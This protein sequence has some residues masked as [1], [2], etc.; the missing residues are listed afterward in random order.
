MWA[1]PDPDH[2]HIPVSPHSS[3]PPTTHSSPGL[4]AFPQSEQECFFRTNFIITSK[5]WSWPEIKVIADEKYFIEGLLPAKVDTLKECSFYL[6]FL[7]VADVTGAPE[8]KIKCWI[9]RVAALMQIPCNVR[10]C[11]PA[12][13]T[14]MLVYTGCHKCGSVGLAQHHFNDRV[15]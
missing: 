12:H 14:V 11:R 10:V 4:T 5:L 8:E 1:G 13:V 2:V 9:I 3:A 15:C 7:T 6:S